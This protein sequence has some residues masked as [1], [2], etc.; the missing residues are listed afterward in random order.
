MQIAPRIFSRLFI[1]LLLTGLPS[2]I[3]AQVGGNET[4]HQIVSLAKQGDFAGALKI[5][6]ATEKKASR[7]QLWENRVRIL[8]DAASGKV[9]GPLAAVFLEVDH[10]IRV[11]LTKEKVSQGLK[12]LS[13]VIKQKP[14]YAPFRSARGSLYMLRGETSKAL[15]D[16]NHAIKLAPNRARYYN[17]RANANSRRSPKSALTDYA[18]ALTLSPKWP[19]A[20]LANRGSLYSRTKRTTEALKD[21]QD[22]ISKREINPGAYYDRGNLYSRQKRF[23][24][25]IT[26]YNKALKH[27]PN[28]LQA[29]TNRGVANRRIGK[30]DAAIADHTKALALNPKHLTA[31]MGRAFA[32]SAKGQ[33]EAALKDI[34]LANKLRPNSARLLMTHAMVASRAGKPAEEVE[35]LKNLL[36]ALPPGQNRR[37]QQTSQRI[38][39]LESRLENR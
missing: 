12:R 21:F 35:A 1:A 22:S 37:K 19:H 14:D 24:K 27:D 17:A 10:G 23:D 6:T 13:A 9:A 28:F 34:R 3:H 15:I 29:Y 20:I 32:Y 39:Q 36:R 25:A 31:L 7:P 4:N 8:Q 33:G 11:K 26:D 18:K 30:N 2:T 16:I 5:A 38:K